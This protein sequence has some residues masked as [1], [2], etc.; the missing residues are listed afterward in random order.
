MGLE[1]RM[2][3]LV[4][5]TFFSWRASPKSSRVSSQV[6]S[7][8]ASATRSTSLPCLSVPHSSNNSFTSSSDQHCC[9]LPVELGDG[10]LESPGFGEG[11]GFCSGCPILRCWERVYCNSQS[12]TEGTLSLGCTVLQGVCKHQDVFPWLL[13]D[14][15]LLCPVA[16]VY[17]APS[18]LIKQV[19]CPLDGLLEVSPLASSHTEQSIECLLQI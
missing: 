14:F 6:P 15:V 7:Y 5:L 9:H 19:Q 1:R 11:Q 3:V 13:Q 12:L 8:S 17:F 2:K 4:S 18:S 16:W 10:P